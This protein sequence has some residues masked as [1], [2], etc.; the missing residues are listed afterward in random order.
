[1]ST[2]VAVLRNP[3]L[4]DFYERL[5][6]KPAQQALTACMRELLVILNAMLRHQTPWSAPTPAVS[7]RVTG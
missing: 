5:K 2:V 1:M 7:L 3:I 4:K 6:G